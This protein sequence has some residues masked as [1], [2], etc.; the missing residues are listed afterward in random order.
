MTN[1]PNSNAAYRILVTGSRGK[2]SLVRL[3]FAGIAARRL[4]ARARITGVLPRELTPTGERVITRNSHGHVLEMRWWLRQIADD[5]EAIV[6]ENSAVTPELQPLAA[7][8]MHPSLIVWTNA[9]EDHQEVWGRGRA[10]AE[11]ALVRG[12][13]S[14]TPLVV[15]E[16]IMRSPRLKKL[17][18]QREKTVVVAP[19]YEDNFRMSNL[20]LARKTLEHIGLLDETSDRAM[21]SLPPDIGDFRVF[22]PDAETLLAV[23][24]SANDIESTEQLFSL[25]DWRVEDTSL[26]FSDRPDRP[27]R[28]KSFA[29]FLKRNWREVKL[30]RSPAKLEE[31]YTWIK[32]KQVFGCGNIAGIPLELLN[33]LLKDNCKWI[34]PDA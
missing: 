8:W 20:S 11:D 1:F 5:T 2:S 18:E 34:I 6:M 24:F 21:V 23:A 15:C 30:L 16:E 10:A 26:I 27:E 13:P 29:S 25:L 7:R 14:E 19:Y 17:L 9:R 31:T 28:R 33:H 32:K 12:I 22:C 3:I 4:N